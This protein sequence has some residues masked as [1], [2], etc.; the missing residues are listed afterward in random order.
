MTTTTTTTTMTMMMM[1]MMVTMVMVMMKC[2]ILA[3]NILSAW[4]TLV[5][6]IHI[7]ACLWYMVSCPQNQCHNKHMAERIDESI[8]KSACLSVVFFLFRPRTTA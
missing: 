4:V 2:S 8:S 5:F 6:V 3:V 7:V 1:T